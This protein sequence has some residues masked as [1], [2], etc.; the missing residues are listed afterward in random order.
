[1]THSTT[2]PQ[3]NTTSKKKNYYV[4]KPK[5]Y[6]NCAECGKKLPEKRISSKKYCHH[7]C[8]VKKYTRENKH[9]T[10]R[11][12]INLQK[13]ESICLECGDK[14]SFK[15]GSNRKRCYPKCYK[16]NYARKYWEKH[17]KRI[18]AQKRKTTAS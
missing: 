18:N 14:F 5:K 4:C 12:Y 7:K 15:E 8:L 1:M 9:K 6:F 2:N 10:K 17:G 11:Y 3:L 13:I 16:K